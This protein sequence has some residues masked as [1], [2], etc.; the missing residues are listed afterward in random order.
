M[1][2]YTMNGE[3][4]TGTWPAVRLDFLISFWI[5]SDLGPFSKRVLQISEQIVSQLFGHPV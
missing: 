4:G 2:K 3:K 1:L 5:L